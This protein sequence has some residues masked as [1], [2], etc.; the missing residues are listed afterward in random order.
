MVL[1]KKVLLM[2][3]FLP[4]IIGAIILLVGCSCSRR[5]ASAKVG[6]IISQKTPR[7]D[8]MFP[9]EAHSVY[10]LQADVDLNGKTYLIPEGVTIVHKKGMIKNGVLIGNGTIIKA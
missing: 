6:E 1:F 4:I 8:L 3:V 5:T 9:T 2:S 10:S 7:Y